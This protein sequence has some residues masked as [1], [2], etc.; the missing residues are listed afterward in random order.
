MFGNNFMADLYKPQLILK[1]K[2]LTKTMTVPTK[3]HETD[4]C[5]DIYADIPNET[6][7]IMKKDFDIGEIFN[8]MFSNSDATIT[9]SGNGLAIPP[10]KTVKVPTGFATNI[11]HG[12]WAAVFA[13]SGL[14]TKQSLRPANCVAVI[15]EPYTG[16]WF[17]PIHNDSDEDQIIHHGDRIAQF[18]LLPYYATKLTEVNELES[19]DRGDGGFGSSGV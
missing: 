9:E 8:S 12:Y 5:F 6:Y 2:R 4:A 17:I 18:T 13:R 1:F 11:P 14:A 15:D 10:H 16:E 19:T 7:K 3:A